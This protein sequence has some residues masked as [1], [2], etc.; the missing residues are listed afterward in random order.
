MPIFQETPELW[1]FDVLAQYKKKRTK[2]NCKKIYF[3]LFF[4]L[5]TLWYQSSMIFNSQIWV[6]HARTF[7]KF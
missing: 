2:K 3:F 7:V 6:K 5:L 4:Y 1:K